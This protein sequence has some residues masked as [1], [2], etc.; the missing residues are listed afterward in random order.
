MSELIELSEIC[1]AFGCT[2]HTVIGML[3][4]GELPGVKFGRD[5]RVPRQAFWQRVNEMALEQAKAKR[6]QPATPDP[7]A[8]ILAGHTA[9]ARRGRPQLPR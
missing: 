2:E 3:R 8:S 6:P 9:V 7:V 4:D 1:E 5:W